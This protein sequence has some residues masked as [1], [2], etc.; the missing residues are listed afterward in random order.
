MNIFCN[1]CG[2]CCKLI[3]V[4]SGDNILVRDGFQIIDDE[5][6]SFLIKIDTE[7]IDGASR[8]LFSDVEFFRCKYLINDK[9]TIDTKPPVCTNYPS[10]P[11]AIVPE[12]CA[13][14]GDIFIKNEELKRKIR[15]I[16]EEIL[17]YEVLISTD[18]KDSASY[19]K[20]IENLNRFVNKYKDFGSEDW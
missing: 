19:K 9:C 4:K 14:I 5:F 20:I 13:C 2:M 11:L 18:D 12:E 17:D 15:K 1:G 16:K 7:S 8:E 3:P 6:Q 10:S